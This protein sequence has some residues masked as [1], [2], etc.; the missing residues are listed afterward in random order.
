MANEQ[1]WQILGTDLR[2]FITQSLAVVG[3]SDMC[4]TM[5]HLELTDL[6]HGRLRRPRDPRLLTCNGYLIIQLRRQ[7]N[8]NSSCCIRRQASWDDDYL[9]WVIV[10]CI[11]C[12]VVDADPRAHYSSCFCINSARS[13]YSP[14]SNSVDDDHS[15]AQGSR[16]V[17]VFAQLHVQYGH[18]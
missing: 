13:C 8:E 10:R 18:C 1:V 9:S 12:P 6:H 7:A 5:L 17:E 4:M 14:L 15:I 2:R 16:W 11:T 3:V